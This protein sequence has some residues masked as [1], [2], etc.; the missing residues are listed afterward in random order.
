MI[1]VENHVKS[2]K[3]KREDIGKEK[4]IQEWTFGRR[5]TVKMFTTF[6]ELQPPNKNS[7]SFIVK[8]YEKVDGVRFAPDPWRF[9]RLENNAHSL[10][11]E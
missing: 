1:V 2:W 11:I 7:L 5:N 4:N 8:I 10:A 3:G 9:Y 6:S